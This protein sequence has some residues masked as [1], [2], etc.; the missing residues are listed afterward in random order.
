MQQI[1]KPLTLI[2]LPAP[3]PDKVW[4]H[5]T[6]QGDRL[7]DGSNWPRI[8][9]VTPSY[10]QGKFL[11]ATIR[12]VLWQQY[13]N[14]EYI[15]IDGGSTDNSA[16]IIKKYEKHLAYW[17]SEPDNGQSHAINK[18]F[19]RC[20]GDI[21]AWLNSDDLYLPYTLWKIAHLFT[22]NRG[23]DLVT[24]GWIS[25]DVKANTLFALR[26]CGNGSFPTTALMLMQH[27]LIGQPSTFWR[28]SVWESAGPINENLHYAMDHAFFLR[29]C[30]SGFNYKLISEYLSI[31]QE[32]NAQKTKQGTKYIDEFQAVVISYKDRSEWQSLI[33]CFKLHLAK[34]MFSLIHHRNTHP[35][36]GLVPKF[37]AEYICSWLDDVKNC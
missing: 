5:W 14:L 20:T 29:C 16:E 15:I 32:H 28:K 2:D 13:P 4:W 26:P 3:S 12:S 35:R 34:R 6:E 23:V 11:E 7:P 27:G 21:L 8:S 24:G 19:A 30:D 36:L 22:T 9:I 10:N 31:I 1:T 18:G 17:V 33:G 25:N 37:D